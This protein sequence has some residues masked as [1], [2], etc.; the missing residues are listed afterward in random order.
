MKL[1]ETP[2]SIRHRGPAL[3]QHS[4]EILAEHGYGEDE[5]A[6]LLTSGVVGGR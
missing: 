2:A 4:R 6:E 3:G 1:S 5:V